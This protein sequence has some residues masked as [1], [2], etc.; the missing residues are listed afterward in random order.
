V[1]VEKKKRKGRTS[2]GPACPGWGGERIAC[3]STDR[4]VSIPLCEIA[5][6]VG[7]CGLVASYAC[8]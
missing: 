2:R 1:L 4:E 6:Y 7:F 8:L 5:S 3:S